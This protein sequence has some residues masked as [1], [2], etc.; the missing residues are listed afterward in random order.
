MQTQEPVGIGVDIGG[1]FTD[2]VCTRPGRP[3]IIRKVPSTPADPSGAV[4]TAL[5]QLADEDGIDLSSVQRFV[6][7]TTVATN[8]VIQRKGARIGLLATEGFGDVLEIGRQLR[9]AMYHVI[10]SPET[11]TFIAP[12]SRRREIPE[13]IGADGGVVR[14][15]DEA[16]VNRAVDELVADGVACIAI[17]FLFSFANPSHEQRA[18]ALIRERHPGMMVSISSEV[19][20]TFREYERTLVAV[21]DAY[22]KPTVDQYL[23][24]L[25]A[26]IASVGVPAALQIMQSRGGITGAR[27]ARTRPVRLFLSGP[28]AGVVGGNLVGTANGIG[29]LITVD[30]GGTSSDIT[31]ITDGEPMIRAEGVICGYPV[32]VPMVDVNAIGAGGG[33]IAWIDG[34]G[35]LKVGP[36]SAGSDPGPACYGRGGEEATVTDASLVLGYLDPG[37]FAGGTL[38]L[39]EDAARAVI[40]RRIAQPLGI[41]VEEAA[42]GIHRVVNAQMAEGI[43]LV[44]I[45][46]GV[47]PRDY[48]L[49]PLGGA[50]PLHA[51]ALAE[52]LSIERIILPR[53]PGVL[54]AIGLLAA[55]VEHEV[56]SAFPRAFAA[57]DLEAVRAALAPL[58]QRCDAMMQQE[59]VEPQAVTT[60]YLADVCQVGQSHHLEVRLQL[61]EP[62]PLTRLLED[63]RKL[64]DQIYGH[65]ADAPARF[66]NLRVVKRCSVGHAPV[67]DPPADPARSAGATTSPELRSVLFPQPWGRQ[68]TVIRQRASLPVGSRIDGPAIVEQADTTTLISPGWSAVVEPTLDIIIQRQR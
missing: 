17:A 66:V 43:R 62:A 49:V 53:H 6:H 24:N 39:R 3:A 37:Y 13:R 64:H 20:P 31:L 19:D 10:L 46:R 65:S 11:P 25:A 33:S 29:N 32:R 51:T 4:I 12:G 30:I 41:S 40:D 22:V 5:R 47:D 55:P 59:G 1:T 26:G 58:E 42:L 8:A 38:A 56:S 60:D 21:F 52:D 67:I 36:H 34:A 14:P 57:T 15:L 9:N 61:D 54:S 48:T 2:I 44:S 7:G 45:R 63:F 35:S 16:A 68:D 23:E 28:A 18:R 50:G 27:I